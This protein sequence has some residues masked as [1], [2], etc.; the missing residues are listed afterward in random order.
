MFDYMTIG[1]RI[2]LTLWVGTLWAIGYIAAPVLF[3]VI[4]DRFVAGGIAGKMFMA[5]NYLGLACGALLLASLIYQTGAAWRRR[6]QVWVLVA[7]LV[8]I[9]AMEFVLQPLMQALK[10][11]SPQGFT[12]GTP[13]A[14]RFGMLHGVSS[15]L[16]LATS[17][18]GL[19]LVAFGLRG[20]SQ[21]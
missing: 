4:F 10:M 21:S 15:L 16:Y 5:V 8:L 11:A 6:W 20:N 3:N 19:A 14:A 7:M 1:Q 13:E 9:V 17:L 18:M 2:L 12:A